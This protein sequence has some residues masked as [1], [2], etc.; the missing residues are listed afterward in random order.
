MGRVGLVTIGRV[1]LVDSRQSVGYAIAATAR[2]SARPGER[3]VSTCGERPFVTIQH[4][5]AFP[6]KKFLERM[7]D[8]RAADALP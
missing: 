2:S 8:L 7:F 1:G 4:E 3:L 5:R 6:V